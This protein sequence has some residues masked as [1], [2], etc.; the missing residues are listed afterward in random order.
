MS[1]NACVQLCP[2]KTKFPGHFDTIMEVFPG[3]KTFIMVTVPNDAWPHKFSNLPN[4]KC[5]SE[6][7]VNFPNH[8][9]EPVFNWSQLIKL[10][11][12]IPIKGTMR[13]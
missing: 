8:W 3:Q 13:N 10:I 12:T 7:Y 1:L 2:T 4:N 9:P 6:L 5:Y 11:H